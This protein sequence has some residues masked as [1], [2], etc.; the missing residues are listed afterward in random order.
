MA[1]PT[2]YAPTLSTLLAAIDMG[3]NSF[4]LL[5]VRT[6]PDGKF[7]AVDQFKEPVVLGRDTTSSSN[8]TPFALSHHSHLLAFESLKKFQKILKSYKIGKTKVR[9]VATAAVR[10]AVNKAEFLERVRE[11]VGL[12][13]DVLPGEEEARLV[14]LGMLQFLPIYEK[15]VL[16][17]DI[18]GGST[19]FVIGKE[20]NVVFGAS[21]KLGHVN[22]T[23]KFGGSEGNAEIMR[24]HI[25]S[26]IQEYG[27]VEKIQSC[28]F[29]V[30]VGS[31]GT[32]K[33]VEKAVR[34]GYADMSN[35]LQVGNLVSFGDGK[36]DW[37]LSRG[38]VK[39][40]VGS[41]CSGGEAERIRREK[42]FERRSEF[43]VAGAVLLEEIF[44]MIG[45]EEMEVSG[46]ALAE[47]VIAESLAKGNEGYDLNANRKW[48]SIVRLAMRFNGK[49]RMQAA[50]Q[51]AGI[52]KEI[53]EGLRKCDDLTNNQVAASLDDKDLEYLEA[54]CLLHN[55][56][57]SVGKKGY[58]KHSYSII[59]NGDHLHGYSTEE[60]K[61]I[62][63]LAKHHRKKLPNVDHVSF[64]ELPEEGK[65]KF[66]FLCAIIRTSVALQ[67]HRRID[68]QQLEFSHF[69][70]GF[71]LTC[72]G[73]K[74][75]NSP[76]DVVQSL[77]ED[78]GDEL[79]QELAHFKMV[80]H[81]ELFIIAPSS[82]SG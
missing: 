20:G 34:F 72:S 71:R 15:S 22:L 12:E 75:Q 70:E 73:V 8:P 33:A 41:L 54:A 61:L 26:V 59:M 24:Q 76:P 27:L 55:I 6:Y 53:F 7:F 35:M 30:V 45:I 36:R 19:E 1:S 37:K 58:H 51:C 60:V 25:R 3:T 2:P 43:M 11:E 46:Y 40:V 77:A 21:L 17:V 63:L 32:I 28:G 52:A 74:D 48:S 82:A 66:K 78:I 67:Q 4:K 65:M 18:G 13:V 57:I 50:A 80:F 5:I 42:F 39:G 29:D 68:F 62:A 56:G 81:E 10:E 14:Y 79:R 31:S 16:G 44:E 38:E 47:G 49:K 69:H 9:C 23:Q 64:K